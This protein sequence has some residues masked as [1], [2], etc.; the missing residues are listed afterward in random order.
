MPDSAITQ[1]VSS[2]PNL[3]KAA[4]CDLWQQLFK[5]EP[6][7]AMRKDLMLRIIAYRLQEQEFGGLSDT[8]VC[9]RSQSQ[10]NSFDPT[11]DQTRHSPR[12]PVERTSPCGE[13]GSEKL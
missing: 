7:P 2:L 4:L 8:R 11:V 6:P 13:R 12:A 3:S 10:R 9:V 1:Q 5:K